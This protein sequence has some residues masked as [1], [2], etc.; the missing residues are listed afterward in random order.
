MRCHSTPDLAPKD[1]VKIYGDTAGFHEKVGTIRALLSSEY[2]LKNLDA[3][4]SKMTFY[5][6]I[7]TFFVFLI[8]F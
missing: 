4:V 2:S 8:S 6:A 7:L 5:I 3:L 1:L